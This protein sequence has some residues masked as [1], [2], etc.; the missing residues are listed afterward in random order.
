MYLKKNIIIKK[1]VFSHLKKYQFRKNYLFF[2]KLIFY[3]VITQTIIK[4][5]IDIYPDHHSEDD[6][7]F[8]K[9]QV[10][11]V[12]NESFY[13]DL[14]Y[15]TERT[16]KFRSAKYGLNYRPI[17]CKKINDTDP[18][19]IY[20][21]D[22]RDSFFGV[23]KGIKNIAS[24]LDFQDNK[25]EET[26]LFR[27]TIKGYNFSCPSPIRGFHNKNFEINFTIPMI[28]ETDMNIN[29]KLVSEDGRVNNSIGDIPLT[30]NIYKK[31]TFYIFPQEKEIYNTS[32]MI[33]KFE[34]DGPPI[35]E[36]PLSIEGDPDLYIQFISE[37]PGNLVLSNYRVTITDT[38]TVAGTPF[39]STMVR[40]KNGLVNNCT[41]DLDC[42]IG[43]MCTYFNC[44]PCH[45][46]CTECYQDDINAVG[47]NHCRECNVL[48]TTPKPHDGYCDVGYV[49]VTLFK[50]FEVK[51]KPDGEDFNDRET[52]GFWIFFTDTE[53]S[54]ERKLDP[55][56]RESLGLKEEPEP[57]DILHHIVLKNRFVITII[58]RIRKFSVYCHVYENL[59]SR[60]TSDHIFFRQDKVNNYDYKDIK[61][62]D[63]FF[64]P[65]PN[66]YLNFS[67]PSK[68]QKLY[69]VGNEVDQDNEFDKTVDGHW[70]HVSCAESFD[71]GLYYLKTVINGQSEYK[72][73]H[74]YHEPFLRTFE[75]GEFVSVD[76]ENDKYFKPII[77]GDN[78]LYLQFLNF[79][80]SNSKVYLRHLTL[81]KEYIP[82]YM[83]YMYFDYSGVKDFYEL[84]YYIPFTEL[85]YG[86]KYTIKGYSYEYVEEEIIL[87]LNSTDPKEIIGDV[88]PPL[89]FIHLNFPPMNKK[90]REIDLLLNETTP[91]I[92]GEKMKYVYEDNLAMCCVAYFNK[93]ENK[94]LDKCVDVNKLQ[95]VGVNYK[96]SYCD[97]VCQDSMSCLKDEYTGDELD[98][99]GGFCTT[100]NNAYNLFYRCE[101]DRI[102]YYFQFSGFYNSS[103]MEKKIPKMTSYIIDF[104]Y[105]D[106][107]FLKELREKFF[108]Y[109]TEENHYILHTNVIDLYYKIKTISLKDLKNGEDKTIGYAY[110]KHAI[111]YSLKD[112]TDTNNLLYLNQEWNR[113]VINALYNRTVE[114]Y[115]ITI[116]LNY[117]RVE[118]LALEPGFCSSVTELHPSIGTLEN[119]IFCDK[120][121]EDWQGKIIHWATGYY[122]NFRI[123]DGNNAHPGL[124]AQ[125]DQYFPDY[126]SRVSAIKYYFPMTNKYMSNN[127]IIDPKSKEFFE[128]IA[129]KY[130]LKKYNFSSKFDLIATQKLYG[131]CYFMDYEQTDIIGQEIIELKE[132]VE[133][134]ERCWCVLGTDNSARFNVRCFKCKEGYFL[135]EEYFCHKIGGY[136]FKSP[137]LLN[138]KDATIS[139]ITLIENQP[140]VTVCFWFKTFGFSGDDRMTMF[141][142]GN[143]LEIVFSSS[144]NDP[145][146]PYGLSLVNNERLVANVFGFREM[147]GDWLFLS[148]AY[149]REMSDFGTNYFPTMMKFEL[150]LKPY[151]VNITN[152][153]K[154]MSLD[155]FSVKKE[156]YGFICR[157]QFF[158]EY[159]I[160]QYGNEKMLHPDIVL[161][162]FYY[163][164]PVESFF[165]VSYSDKG[166]FET[167]YLDGV[168]IN[169]FECVPDEGI[170]HNYYGIL[171]CV[172]DDDNFYKQF[173]QKNKMC[174]NECYKFSNSTNECTCSAKNSNSQMIIRNKDKN[175]CVSMDFINFANC[176]DILIENV[177]TAK[178]TKRYT[179]Q[180]W[181]YAYNY[182]NGRF[183]GVEFYWDG[184]NKIVVEKGDQANGNNKYEFHCIPYLNEDGTVPRKLT[185]V[186]EINKWNYLSC[187]VDFVEINYYINVNTYFNELELERAN[188]IQTT[189]TELL[190]TQT[191]TTL[192]IKDK[193][194]FIDWGLL[195]FMHIRLWNWCYFNAEFLSRLNLKT[196]KLFPYLLEQWEPLFPLIDKPYK[197][198]TNFDVW[199]L[200]KHNKFQVRFNQ[201]YGM[202][203]L[204]DYYYNIV[205]KCSEN[206]YYYDVARETCLLF[207]DMSKM[208]DFEFTGL[209][210]A[211]SGSY[212][213]SIW[214]FLEDATVLSQGIHFT[215]SKHLQI[216][217][218][219]TTRLEAYCFPQGY[220]SDSVSN[221]N[222]QDKF[223]SA[224]NAGQVYLVDEQTSES[225]VWINVICAMSHYNRRY[226]VNGMDEKT[227]NEK[228]LI[229]EYLYKDSDGTITTTFYPMRYYFSEINGN[230]LL[231]STLAISNIKSTKRIYFRA[232]TLFRDY[233]PYWYNK[234]LRN[235]NLYNLEIGKMPSVLF[236]A[237]FTRITVSGNTR[238]LNY[239]IQYLKKNAKEYTLDKNK[240]VNI[241][242]HSDFPASTTT[243]ELCANFRFMP[244]CEFATKVK[245]KYDPNK[246]YCVFIAS[247]DL[248]KLNAY[249]CM[250]EDTP[251]SC[252]PNYYITVDS[253]GKIY[254]SG[255]CIKDDIRQ[256]GTN[257]THGICN[258]ICD[259]GTK[260]CP[261][262]GS[263]V[264]KDYQLNY[265]CND[266]NYRVGYHCVNTQ[267]NLQSALFFSK[268]YNSPNFCVDINSETQYLFRTGYFLEFWIK[269]DKMLN[270]CQDGYETKEIEYY[271]RTDPH[272]IYLD[273]TT[274][275]FY[276]K[277]KNY[278]NTIREISGI[279]DYEWNKF[280]IRTRINDKQI[281]LFLNFDIVN[282]K[283]TLNE[284]NDL[285]IVADLQLNKIS[286]YSR[287]GNG[288]GAGNC[289]E[290][291]INWGSA[292]YKNIRVWDERTTTI[293]MVQDF[294]NELFTEFPNSLVLYYPLT[295]QYM[296]LNVVTEIISGVDN[297]QVTHPETNNF[298]NNDQNI[299]Y[300]YEINHDWGEK[301]SGYYIS[302]LGQ[303]EEDNGE[304]TATACNPACKRCFSSTATNCYACNEGYVL[305]GMECIRINGY[306]LKIPANTV[307]TIIPFKIESNNINV[308][309]LAAWTFCI[310]MKFEGVVAGISTQRRII[311]FKSDTYIAY[312][313]ETTNLIFI[314]QS[315]EAFRDTNFKAY[316]GI[317]IPICVADYV[318]GAVLNEI[319]PNML[320]IN[321]N[322][323][324][325]PFNS[326]FSIPNEG[327]KMDQISLH[328][329]VIAFFAD[330]RIYDHFI[331]GNFGTVIS[332]TD[333]ANHLLIYYS[334]AGSVC[335][336]AD[337]LTT[338]E[339]I[340][341]NCVPDYNI[342]VD[343]S[344]KCVDGSYFFDVQYEAETIPCSACDE[345]CVTLCFQ[346]NNQQCTCNMEDGLFWLRKHKTTFQTYCEYLPFIDFSAIND[347]TIKVPSSGTYESTLE[348]W[349]FAY[350][351]NLITFNFKQMTIAWNLHNKIV[352]YTKNNELFARCYA[353]WDEDNESYYTEYIEQKIYGYKW[354]SL[355][356]GSEFISRYPKYFFNREQQNL[357]IPE[358]P[359]D[360]IGKVTTLKIINDENSYDSYG[361][362]FLR[363]L[364]LWQQ[365][366]F[367]YIDTSFIDLQSFGLYNKELR[368]TY[369][370]YPGLIGYFKN[371]FK[372]TDY[373]AELNA[374]H[375]YTI[376]NLLGGDANVE[377]H[378]VNK[379][380]TTRRTN[381]I[382]YNIVDPTNKGNYKD[383]TLCEE[384]E[385]YN[386]SSDTCSKPITT[387][388]EYPGDIG[389]KCIT[390]PEETIYIN[391]VDGTCTNTC[392]VE[393][394]AR[395]DI[396]ECRACHYTCYTCTGPFYN[397]CT[398]CTGE[399]SLVPQLHICIPSCELYGLTMDPDDHNMC[400]PFDA[401]AELVN[402]AEGIPIDIE[403]FEELIA[404]VTY[405]TSINYKTWW[406]FDPNATREINNLTN[407]TFPFDDPFNGDKS[408]L[409]TSIDNRF[410]ELGKK[411]VVNLIITTESLREP[412]Y[413]LSITVPFVLT[414]NSYP[415][416]GKFV[417][418]PEIG[419]YNTTTFL[420]VCKNY[421]DDTTKDLLYIFYAKEKGTK[422]TSI[423]RGWSSEYETT[424]NFTVE[425]Y[426]LP[427]STITIS[428]VIR[429]NYGATTIVSQDIIIA[430]DPSNGIYDL[431]KA[432][433]LY[434][435]PTM[436]TDLI[437][438][439]RSQYLMSLGIDKYKIL[440]PN[441][442]QTQYAP[443]I[444]LSLITKTDPECTLDFCNYNGYCDLMDEFSNCYCDTGFIG[445]N[446][447]VD[448]NGYE[449]LER[450]YN[451]LFDKLIGDLKENITYYEFETFHNLYFGACQFFQDKNFFSLNLDTFLALAMNLYKDSILNNTAE[452][453]DLLD[454]YYSY[455]IMLMEQERGKIKY[456]TGLKV[457]NISL[458]EESMES[459]QESFSY[460]QEE[461]I[462]LMKYL[463][464]EYM[465]TKNSFFYES[466]NFYLA[467]APVERGFDE[468]SFFQERK[469]KYKTHIEFMNC[470]NYIELERLKNANYY[471]YL[472]FIEYYYFP[473]SFNNTLLRNNTG[474]YIDFRL[475]DTTTGKFLTISGCEDIYSVIYTVP[476]SGYYFLDDFNLQKP[477]YDP[478]VYKGPDD[479]I[480]ADP[481]YIMKNG[482]VTD[483]T[484][485]ERIK[486]YNRIHNITPMYFDETLGAFNESE[487]SYLNFTNDTNFI[488]FKSSHFGQFASFFVPNNATF[489]TNGRFFYL[490]RPRIFF[491]G[492]NYFNSYGGF[493]FLALIVFY[494]IFI[495]IFSIYDIKFSSQLALIEYIKEQVVN[496]YLH[497]KKEKDKKKYIPNKLRN[498]YDH[499]NY[500]DTR[501]LGP[502]AYS[503]AMTSKE[504]LRNN[505]IFGQNFKK[506]KFFEQD[507]IQE[508]ISFDDDDDI[509]SVNTNKKPSVK[510][511]FF[512]GGEVK[513]KRKTAEEGF[514][515]NK[516]FSHNLKNNEIENTESKRKFKYH[517]N[518]LPE[519][520]ENEEDARNEQIQDFADIKLTFFEFL[521]LNIVSRSILINS[522]V[523]VSI[524]NPRWKKLSLLMTEL[525]LNMTFVSIFLTADEKAVHS[526]ILKMVEY[527]LLSML[528]SDFVIYIIAF[529]F[530]FS[531]SDQRRLFT[532]VTQGG[533][534]IIDKEWKIIEKKLKKM[535]I[536]GMIIN[537]IIW[538]Y[539]FYASFGFTLVWKYQRFGYLECFGF[540][541]VFNYIIFEL[542]IELFIAI[543][544]LQ[545][546]HNWFLRRIAEGLNNLRNY[547]CLSP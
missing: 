457:R 487:V 387:H 186:I 54:R 422:T 481:I 69:M 129:G 542:L 105:Y 174:F 307:N 403:S 524:F 547:R 135:T 517:H 64:F 499:R 251:I 540:C 471:L 258:S 204:D 347:V 86:N 217:V 222:I 214:I 158:N 101:D 166:C 322:K 98:Y 178:L 200:D 112:M 39:N 119:I 295:I 231:H 466:K 386:E 115:H 206:G 109:P 304:V 182:I 88:S 30:A 269:L 392:P 449:T 533:Q 375:T 516:D 448:K 131:K 300:N 323:E 261:G 337:D 215:W 194:K 371:D 52:L 255:G 183:G 513:Y 430:N 208:K 28:A 67:V 458:S 94:C 439:H 349:F 144:D 503:N 113:I 477:M 315:Q 45:S 426:A 305:Y 294:N 96:S 404:E 302:A 306:Y 118:H 472:F 170:S 177:Q 149:H 355:R 282:P 505:Q 126:I 17:K 264:L 521:L 111:Y 11:K 24:T 312:D 332:S 136:F 27:N 160:G 65:H 485:E 150:A 518:Y 22:D 46:T 311:L 413:N 368:K 454:Y 522:F 81:F 362:V 427:S 33:F 277:F 353:L 35:F 108:G 161:T 297:F 391:I 130:K 401:D 20:N 82:T 267:Y 191:K 271:F 497:Y 446:C 359:M 469:E 510:N 379:W 176:Q 234:Y 199:E 443:S 250:E 327:V 410:F 128:I 164:E 544:Y 275:I 434:E 467:L 202:N 441:L 6:P 114:R 350:S 151:E 68:N 50:D 473:Y 256:P 44:T 476:Y 270:E 342:Y 336:Q 402:Y 478:N 411:Y 145:V 356:C 262:S 338:T 470:V 36:P 369:G 209:P 103:K 357:L 313:L 331:Q 66:Y 493:L 309:D 289:K 116:C 102:D 541:F 453:F 18:D 378:L 63:R 498:P 279:N 218:I 132:C 87:D 162:P 19:P 465:A 474:P 329:E 4:C 343:A 254:C 424:S 407:M 263:S 242:L 124:L 139:K 163:P 412:Q 459:Y 462:I 423:L 388:C 418:A 421:E 12:T 79:N 236:Y 525:C 530:K 99:N 198:F 346:S 239:M 13:Y 455:E 249:Y 143:D 296:D 42:F 292:Y 444:D 93:E 287:D 97:Y 155:S 367:E 381:F 437:C 104:W 546:K 288:Y 220:Y 361:F 508:E 515:K 193:T 538:I 492:P 91:L 5:T 257:A 484:I 185:K 293:R 165:P 85:S 40:S 140:A 184:H 488:V 380:K 157:L 192:S 169:D 21:M 432:L 224:L 535:A 203:V 341:V 32:K 468:I 228:T 205:Q 442:Y 383:L 526:N 308:K 268:C 345:T 511:N 456:L 123:W 110:N 141:T 435:L 237:D 284:E 495:N 175:A 460:I 75:N 134:C 393:Y 509:F 537:V 419:L 14:G 26:K 260:S 10:K 25:F 219:K 197:Y 179:M 389:D 83:Q 168:N 195:F 370:I 438:Y 226:Y 523:M 409:D 244:L 303:T 92:L 229:N 319:Y 283:F 259:K 246:N 152:V 504:D 122:K 146:R 334:L 137:N 463:V 519:E 188:L 196:S 286:F 483:S 73:D 539:T 543:L 121:C 190:L 532:L 147:M 74:L 330:L 326:D 29:V 133:G 34:R 57:E 156:F 429:D 243:F 445:R 507:I 376:I 51:V 316:F 232:I 328:Y 62:M 364:K 363:E 321:V 475:L 464:N 49:D 240:N 385:V 78:V 447:H 502:A 482:N 253:N 325:L 310:Y 76:V 276:Y 189:P 187:A 420:I 405:Y 374:P 280:Y 100:L 248:T 545:R 212:S 416:N 117:Y 225:A 314:V 290:S 43:F 252:L 266:N 16:D 207:T 53:L 506:K 366:N 373:E 216:T 154:D 15:F 451:E 299:F 181:M 41:K 480:F 90:Y 238:T 415:F 531:V 333:A 285:P 233:I 223:S 201:K 291:N 406:E 452:Y 281:D 344:R 38:K 274:N 461:L 3:L 431:K 272:S 47:M 213:M 529:F 501:D 348:V 31:V 340:D 80:Y 48:S 159:I 125:Y 180:F 354:N 230:I 400:I 494:I 536:I 2:T 148:I 9:S 153:K 1:M 399:L 241:Y 500:I 120:V 382:G 142:I 235:M 377:V 317:W 318:S 8:K 417:I 491:F 512:H 394:Y 298:K 89:N 72:E 59:F 127:K 360:R 436:R 245:M 247:C 496:L 55:V 352:V 7:N 273:T 528:C 227:L 172:K 167:S 278:A 365:Y 324:D 56:K 396:N 520:F 384:G 37:S 486:L 450:Y 301:N 414:M 265:Q 95:Y 479:E 489:H 527:A 534:L 58:Q 395:D 398:S 397:N 171:Y 440:Q 61:N 425:Y 173:T 84:L 106:D 372:I 433:L 71:H 320:T 60:N 211:Y 138:K 23:N 70:V 514:K 408:N 210:L 335:I 339:K 390:C 428:C 351:Y 490:M 77:Y 358:Y 107:Y 221:D